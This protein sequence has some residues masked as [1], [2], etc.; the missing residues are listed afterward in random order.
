MATR[1]VK[2]HL[3]LD[4]LEAYRQLGEA[5][6]LFDV[7]AH[8]RLEGNYD[9]SVEV[10]CGTCDRGGEPVAWYAGPER[11]DPPLYPNPYD[12]SRVPTARTIAQLY[13]LAYLHV[14]DAHGG[15]S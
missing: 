5:A 10:Q 13:G 2:V 11:F 12:E 3:T 8:C 9:G 1:E 14:R 4:G 6:P 7:D 15:P